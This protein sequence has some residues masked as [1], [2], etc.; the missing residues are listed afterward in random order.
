MS[1]SNS[2]AADFPLELAYR[3]RRA[4]LLVGLFC[5]LFVFVTALYCFS[6][7]FYLGGEYQASLWASLRC[8]STDWIGWALI[9]PLLAHLAV[10][11]D[12]STDAGV[13][14][15]VRLLIVATLVLGIVRMAVEYALSGEALVH[16]LLY[17]LPRY[18]FVT[19]FFIGAGV[20][21]VFKHS[22]AVE[23][24]RLKQEQCRP[25]ADAKPVD[26]EGAQYFVV[27]KGNC[28]ALVQ[29]DDIISITASGNYLELEATT[30]TYLMR[31][32][33]KAIEAQL[34]RRRFVRIHRS[35]IV[36][37]AQ[38]DSVS[39]TRLEANLANGSVL[40]VGKK[41]LDSLP[42]FAYKAAN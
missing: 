27:H 2:Q 19:A 7:A 35:H 3:K 33:M 26:T 20:L 30:G 34:D 24:Q 15:I 22:A 5:A 32:T 21:Y 37:L 41:Y 29:C 28:R 17:F 1:T 4:V 16:T 9:A 42:H 40:R 11:E 38:V 31:S 12:I 10:R 18:L 36:S 8:V 6:Y 25:K 13:V 14:A 23:I 39:R